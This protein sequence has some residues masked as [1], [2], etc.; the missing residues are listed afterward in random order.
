[1]LDEQIAKQASKGKKKAKY[2]SY[3]F[4]QP[5]CWHTVSDNR[6]RKSEKEEDEELLKDEEEDE[7]FVFEES[8]PCE[9]SILIWIPQSNAAQMSRAAKCEITKFRV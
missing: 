1:M 2:V 4:N 6:H 9:Y 5:P 3:T 7:P 8:P